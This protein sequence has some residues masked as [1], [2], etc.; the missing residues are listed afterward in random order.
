MLTS[1]NVVRI[2]AV[3]CDCTRRSA[4]RWRSR[5]IGTRCSGR[6]PSAPAAGTAGAA[7]AALAAGAAGAAGAGLRLGGRDHVALGDAPA[8]AGA[9]DAPRHRRPARPSSCA[10]RAAP[11]P[12]RS[13]RRPARRGSGAQCGAAG[14]AAGAAPRGAPARLRLGVDD[15]D[16]FLAAR[17]S[18]RRPCTISTSTPA[19]GAGSSSTTLSVSTSIRF[20]SRR[21]PRRASCAS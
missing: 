11:S 18:R 2:A 7:A 21:P 4:T 3:D 5:D 17:P 20:S 19:S 13:L 12:T 8:A 1:L 9:G 15:R 16:H 14:A 6:L 10:R